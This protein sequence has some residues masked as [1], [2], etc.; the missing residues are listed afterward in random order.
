MN[1][2]R[3]QPSGGGTSRMT[4]ECQVRIC[5]R[6]GVKFP[7]PTRRSGHKGPLIS[8]SGQKLSYFFRAPLRFTR[9]RRLRERAA[10]ALHCADGNAKPRGCARPRWPRLASLLIL[11]EIFEPIGRQRRIAHCGCNAAV[12][13]V[14]PDSPR[15]LAIVGQLV[16]AAV[17]QHVRVDEER[18]AS[19]LARTG[20]HALIARNAQRCA[21]L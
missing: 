16:A 21:T 3:R 7:G 14:V 9:R 5:E 1:N 20:N 15:V 2:G 6:L 18:E 12:A 10:D 13:K 4:R 8:E 19:G 17:P 11:P